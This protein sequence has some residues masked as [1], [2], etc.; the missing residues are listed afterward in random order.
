[1]IP[2]TPKL[3]QQIENNGGNIHYITLEE[4]QHILSN[5]VILSKEKGL[6][7]LGKSK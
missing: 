2:L 1:M 7:Q 5:G 6:E 4:F 3:K